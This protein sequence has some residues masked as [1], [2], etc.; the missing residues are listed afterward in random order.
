MAIVYN[1]TTFSGSNSRQ[2][3]NY[4][5]TNMCTIVKQESGNAIP[6]YSRSGWYRSTNNSGGQFHACVYRI[7]ADGEIYVCWWAC[8]SASHCLLHPGF[9]FNNYVCLGICYA[10]RVFSYTNYTIGQPIIE[11]KG[12]SGECAGCTF[13]CTLNTSQWNPQSVW[14]SYTIRNS[15]SATVSCISNSSTC[16]GGT[17]RFYW[18]GDNTVGRCWYYGYGTYGASSNSTSSYVIDCLC[19]YGATRNGVLSNCCIGDGWTDICA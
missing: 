4:N 18:P 2:N 12:T 15:P 19:F 14:H 9:S 10:D 1:G 8:P 3:I 5:G 11:V 7:D 13:C 17:F 16:C 6:V